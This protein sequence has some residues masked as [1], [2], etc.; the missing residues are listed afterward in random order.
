MI[1]TEIGFPPF[2]GPIEGNPDTGED[3]LVT[4]P[5][6]G[7][8]GLLGPDPEEDADKLVA[9]DGQ[10]VTLSPAGITNPGY[11]TMASF[12]SGGPRN[13]DSFQKPDVT[14]PGVSVFSTNSDSGFRGAYISG[15]RWRHRSSPASRP[16]SSTHTLSTRRRRSRA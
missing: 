10:S 1:N 2:E 14:A 3:F 15:I 9:A 12:T 7:V 6:L 16:S 13:V 11:K 8:R 5:F 4:I